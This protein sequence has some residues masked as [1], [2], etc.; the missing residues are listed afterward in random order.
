MIFEMYLQYVEMG[1]FIAHNRIKRNGFSLS[2]RG[3]KR[4]PNVPTNFSFQFKAT[5][6]RTQVLLSPFEVELDALAWQ[7]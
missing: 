3:R 5:F 4:G 2:R 7:P 6:I 1:F